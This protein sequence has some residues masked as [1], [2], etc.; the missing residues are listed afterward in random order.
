MT[1]EQTK[2]D[3]GLWNKAQFTEVGDQ[4]KEWEAQ[5]NNTMTNIRHDW[6]FAIRVD[7]R[8]FHTFTKGMAKPYSPIMHDCMRYAAETVLKALKCQY[9][10]LQS[11]EITFVWQ[12][13]PEPYE[14]PFGGRK[15]KLLT[16]VASLVSVAFYKNYSRL[17]P[18]DDVR[19]PHFDARFVAELPASDANHK[20]MTEV[21]VMWRE[22]DA[23]R[24]SVSML[25]QSMFSAKAL[26][27]KNVLEQYLMCKD[28]G[29]DWLNDLLP[30]QQRGTYLKMTRAERE[31]TDDELSK[32][33]VDC[34]PED[35]MVMRSIVSPFYFTDWDATKRMVLWM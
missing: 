30:W 31:L 9:V 20:L 6:S 7:G 8:A 23:M 32:I 21:A 4:A 10:Y 33:P 26:H 25:S 29:C 3:L 24:N 13:R 15:V 12:G 5:L 28:A 18:D 2:I 14:H 17:C 27:G 11:D 35:K 22:N 19:M 16:V 34:V 1:T